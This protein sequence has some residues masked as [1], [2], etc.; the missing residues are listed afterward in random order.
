M[1]QNS[2]R[3]DAAIERFH[4][5]NDQYVVQPA[6]INDRD[7]LIRLIGM[8]ENVPDA[9]ARYDWLYA[10]N[11]HGFAQSWIAVER[12]TGRAVGCTSFF[13]RKVLIDGAQHSGSLG[14][15]ASLSRM[16]DVAALPRPCIKQAWRLTARATRNSRLDRL[17]T[18]IYRR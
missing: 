4:E 17:M 11:P 13:P 14:G 12:E 9:S 15:D 7:R 8:M 6:D 3:P 16:Q 5:R 10:S 2:A 18:R 1:N